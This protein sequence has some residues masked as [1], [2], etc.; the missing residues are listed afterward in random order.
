MSV[1]VAGPKLRG[2][3]DQIADNPNKRVEYLVS[4]DI[5]YE[6]A[7]LAYL[8]K[9][10]RVMF[11]IRVGYTNC[12]YTHRKRSSA[13]RCSLSARRLKNKE[14]KSC[15]PVPFFT[16]AGAKTTLPERSRYPEV[17]RRWQRSPSLRSQ[18]SMPDVVARGGRQR[19]DRYQRDRL[20][21]GITLRPQPAAPCR[22][23]PS[24]THDPR[25]NRRAR[26]DHLMPQCS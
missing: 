25:G 11:C 23:D 6:A 13:A 14:C 2:Q 1:R 20:H 7:D 24:N 18:V 10:V 15:R 5:P 4:A 22:A 8:I 12:E 17:V 21:A 3:G 19:N 16:N 26:V 9:N